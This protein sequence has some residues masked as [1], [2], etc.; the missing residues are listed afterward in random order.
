MVAKQFRDYLPQ[1]LDDMG[2]LDKINV[3]MEL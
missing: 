2:R 3:V 1:T